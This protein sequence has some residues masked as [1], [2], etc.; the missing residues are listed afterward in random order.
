MTSPVASLT[1]KPARARRIAHRARLLMLSRSVVVTLVAA[2]LALP[3][4]VFAQSR[5]A[6]PR[7]DSSGA[8]TTQRPIRAGSI[9]RPDTVTVGEPFT[10]LVTIEVPLSATV[11]W[12][13]IGDT[14]AMVAMR[15]PARV[16]SVVAGA[17][18]RETA[19][20][21]LAAWNIGVLPLGVPDVTVRMDSAV[22]AVPLRDARVVVNTVLP[23]DTSLH[24][25]KPARDPF[26]RVV[27]WWQLWWPAAV[28]VA[29]LVALWWLWRRWRTRRVAVVAPTPLD[30][31]ARA[32]HDFERLQRLALV[33]AGE[34]GRAVALAVEVLRT[35]LA[36]RVPS[37]TLA[38]T[39]PELLTAIDQDA[40]VPR[41]RLASLLTDVDVIKFA[42]HEV[43]RERAR[44]LQAE[45]RAIV[46]A[47]EAAEQARRQREEAARRDAERLARE[48]AQ[49]DEDSARK[50]SR[51]P[52]AGAT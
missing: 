3:V 46:E 24:V 21:T 26:P 22:I 16:S 41:D 6:A 30:V 38:Q 48:R 20:Y 18:R 5:I 9:V 4:P 42:H 44:T 1:T 23:G 27:P 52:T 43:P 35:Y 47:I 12:P 7:P 14:A 45:A 31:F 25:P 32:L 36:A 40:R 19:E 15:T 29:L 51:R 39:S 28:V 34:R 11:Q 50:R 33:D 37:S 8:V 49:R 10:L 17:V 13:A 2:V